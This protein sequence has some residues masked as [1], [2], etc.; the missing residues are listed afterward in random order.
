MD[1]YST[2]NSNK[3]QTQPHGRMSDTKLAS[4]FHLEDSGKGKTPLS[5]EIYRGSHP[6]TTKKNVSHK[7]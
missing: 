1:Y 3:L 5:Q 7:N 4:G 6:R 2:I